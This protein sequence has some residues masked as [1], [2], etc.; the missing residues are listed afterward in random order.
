[1][2]SISKSAQQLSVGLQ[3]TANMIQD[4]LTEL[5]GQDCAMM[6][7]VSVDNTL[8]CISN[9]DRADAIKV[10]ETQLERWRKNKA[11]I[12]AHYNP[13]FIAPPQPKE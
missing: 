4:R 9:M 3:D 6:L 11:D 1:M 13:D 7:F 8:Q 2:S 10:M 5:T 12:P